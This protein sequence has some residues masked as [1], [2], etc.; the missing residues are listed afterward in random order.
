MASHLSNIPPSPRPRFSARGDT[1]PELVV[2]DN[3][4]LNSPSSS[5]VA[6]G[7]W[8]SHDE[9][10][11]LSAPSPRGLRPSPTS[12]T[13]KSHISPI[14]EREEK[15]AKPALKRMN[16]LLPPVAVLVLVSSFIF[17][18][19]YE[20]DGLRGVS[21]ENHQG[22]CAQ[23]PS[24]ET[25]A[26]VL[27]GLENHFNL[28]DPRVLAFA[29][30]ADQYL[31]PW[32]PIKGVKS[33]LGKN[34]MI[35]P[36]ALGH[37]ARL[38]PFMSCCGHLKIVDGV[39]YFRYGG[40][41]VTWY[42][43]L[44]FVQTVRMIQDAVE[45]YKLK[46]LRVEFF[47][48]TCDHPMS[49]FSSHWPGRAGFPVMSTELTAD[50][51]DI[52]IPDPL[53]L[54]DAYTPDLKLQTPWEQKISKAVFR[55][56]TTNFQL[57][58]GNWG[59]NTRLRLHRMTDGWPDL[60]EARISRWSHGND[61][62]IEAMEKD[63][64]ELGQYMN[65]TTMNTYKYQV[66]ADGG[67]GSCRTCGVLRSNQLTLRQDSPFQ[68]FY[69]PMLQ[70]GTHLMMLQHTYED[71][72]EKVA[73]AAQHDKEVQAIIER[74]NEMAEW[75]CSWKGRTLYWAV[76]LSKYQ[77]SLSDPA[78]I[79]APASTC[80]GKVVTYISPDVMPEPMPSVRCDDEDV[81]E[82]QTE[83]TFFC[84]GGPMSEEQYVWLTA[85][86]LKDVPKV[87]PP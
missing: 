73:W 3:E 58:N 63:G 12:K 6:G 85:D 42:R 84:I 38:S 41:F 37:V 48:N 62:V 34:G 55:G 33:G 67:G 82:K 11:N 36:A 25:Q 61:K 86:A 9:S 5:R 74:S 77:F 72:P 19:N 35:T 28:S 10:F 45:M 66:V 2:P 87:G 24:F 27:H 21:V 47:V 54:T 75:A 44:R 65:F 40:F 32:A 8:R 56:A 18:W 13:P 29:K 22:F 60:L 4:S 79:T 83:C 52:A 71:L 76:L 78:N 1:A 15:L 43:V 50:T 17:W 57:V 23:Q 14:K 20:N 46:D 31:E 70:D 30:L 80:Q 68:Q 26:E 39:V 69:E 53:D 49:F 16:K 81:N 7:F 51:M 59:A 64:L